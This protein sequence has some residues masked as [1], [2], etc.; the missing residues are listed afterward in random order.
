MNRLEFTAFLRHTLIPDLE[1]DDHSGFAEDF[2]TALQFITADVEA[3]HDARKALLAASAHTPAGSNAAALVAASLKE[4][5]GVLGY[6][7]KTV[8]HEVTLSYRDGNPSNHNPGNVIQ[9][10]RVVTP[11]QSRRCLDLKSNLKD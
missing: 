9:E 6:P 4:L 5:D 1:A 10:D 8:E 3:M 7:S 2:Q 11:P